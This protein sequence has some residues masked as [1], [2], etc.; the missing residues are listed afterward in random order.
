MGLTA[1][2]LNGNG[3]LINNDIIVNLNHTP[4]KA[5]YY[6]MQFTNTTNGNV[7]GEFKI[8]PKPDGT[9]RVNISPM[10]KST[11]SKPNHMV[12]GIGTTSVAPV[13]LNAQA[14][15]IDIIARFEGATGL[16]LYK[17]FIRGG[18]RSIETNLSLAPG[19]ALS[20]TDKIPSWPAYPLTRY[21]LTSSYLTA[22]ESLVPLAQTE[23]MRVKG[24]NPVYFKFL[25]SLG[26]YS[27]WLFESWTNEE[28]NDHIGV[29]ESFSAIQDLG[30]EVEFNL[31]V[32]SKVPRRYYPL[33]VDLISSPEIYIYKRAA[34]RTENNWMRVTSNNNKAEEKHAKDVYEVKFKFK[35]YFNYNPAVV[36]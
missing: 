14:Y 5:I 6:T 11:F 25:N 36:W 27:Y 28:S 3:F 12:N 34:G 13:P 26:G 4:E 15:Q 8:Y 31:S 19:A 32:Y 10:I 2:G 30:N 23:R 22:I 9:A 29:T 16:T 35:K 17:T 24:C 1:Q 7:T 21:T 18:K 20:V 33:M